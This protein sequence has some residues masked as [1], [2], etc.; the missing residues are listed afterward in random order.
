MPNKPRSPCSF[1]RCPDRAVGRTGRCEVHQRKPVKDRR[2]N[3]NQRGYGAAWQ[4]LRLMQLAR[5]PLC[6][7]CLEHLVT[8][9]ATEVH[10][11]TP[12]NEG[13]TNDV[14]NLQ[15]LCRSCHERTK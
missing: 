6:G 11:K 3:A 14:G 10:H 2:P 5:E 4:K 15:S 1:G 12:L 8:E 9:P 13:G 7:V